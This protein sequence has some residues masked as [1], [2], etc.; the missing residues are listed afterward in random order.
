MKQLLTLLTVILFASC[1]KEQTTIEEKKYYIVGN[2]QF[3]CDTLRLPNNFIHINIDGVS[4]GVIY[5]SGKL[6]V[7]T[8]DT[9]IHVY[10]ANAYDGNGQIQ[11]FAG[12]FKA[13][14]RQTIKV[15]IPNE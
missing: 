2:V 13:R 4:V 8:N 12:T 14:D 10:T 3:S 6:T 15:I 11:T 9:L 7:K 1:E 5:N